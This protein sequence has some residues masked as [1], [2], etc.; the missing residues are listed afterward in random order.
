MGSSRR[1]AGLAAFAAAAATAALAQAPVAAAESCTYDPAT[2]EVTATITPG[3]AATLKLVAGEVWFGFVPVA[4]GGATPANTET[5]RVNGTAGSTER[6]V[7][8]YSG[9]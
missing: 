2:R 3:S 8:D 1:L 9:G 6:L 7:V 5:V 4:C